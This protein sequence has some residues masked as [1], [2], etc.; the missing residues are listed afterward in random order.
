VI[1]KWI[2]GIFLGIVLLIGTCTYVGYNRFQKLAGDDGPTRVMVAAP[3]ARVFASLASGDSIATWMGVA[4]EVRV[5]RKTAL[6]VGDT[7]SVTSTRTPPG[8]Q[9]STWIVSEVT[10]GKL[11]VLQMR[12]DSIGVTA[13]TRRMALEAYGGDSTVIVATVGSP[14]LDSA[15]ARRDSSTSNAMM[16]FAT[17]MMLTALRLQ[18]K[19]ELTQLKGRI[20]G[21]AFNPVAT[22]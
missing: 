4:G 11:L 15:A 2:G 19:L 17:K 13:A 7:I 18:S 21:R 12:D 5:S 3:A 20:E 9:T 22:P 16:N 14:M 1:W 10:S 6:R 8:R